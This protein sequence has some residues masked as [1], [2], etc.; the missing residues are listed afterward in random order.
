MA[1]LYLGETEF[2]GPEILAALREAGHEVEV[3][4]HLGRLPHADDLARRYDLIVDNAAR[5]PDD[6]RAVARA[7]GHG[8]GHYVLLSSYLVYPATLRLRP[9]R[10]SDVDVRVD[11]SVR[12][13][14]EEIA[15]VRAVERE[16]HLLCRGQF[17]FTIL[18]PALIDGPGEPSGR[19][20]WFT[21]RILDGG[22]LILPDGK[23]P[24]FRHVSARDLGRAVRTVA[25]A[26]RAFGQTINV[27]SQG[28]F[29]YWGYAAMLRDGLGVELTFRQVPAARWRAAGLSL[30]LG[31][32]AAAAFIE[33][34][35]LLTELGWTPAEEWDVMV[36]L[37]QHLRTH[38][39]VYD[40]AARHR[41]CQVLAESEAAEGRLVPG[42]LP[43]PMAPPRFWRLMAHAGQPASLSF[44]PLPDSDHEHVPLLK[45]R[46]LVLGPAEAMLLRGDLITEPGP[47]AIGHNALLEVLRAGPGDPSPGATC[48]PWAR[49]P[50]GDPRCGFCQ[51]GHAR[52]LG[53]D[54]D[55][56]GYG[57][58]HTPAPH[59][60]EVPPPLREVALLADPLAC[61]LHGLQRLLTE[62]AGPVWICGRG[63]D[64]ALASWLAQ[65]AGRPVVHVD[66]QPL[67]HPEFP[68]TTLHDEIL[69]V[70]RGEKPA[71]TLTIE[72]SGRMVAWAP[73]AEALAPGGVR[74]A[75]L[76]PAAAPGAQ[77]FHP[78]PLCAPDR[79]SVVEAIAL[80]RR[81][82]SYRDLLLRIGPAVPLWTPGDVFLAPPFTQPYLTAE[83]DAQV[84][85]RGARP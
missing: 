78:L 35:P 84:V 54:C 38:G 10:E 25:G 76:R 6:I 43:A 85:P 48:V 4:P 13:L 37:A 59:L 57:V 61:L 12:G 34:S 45:T 3:A 58:C 77:G 83:E 60:I 72:L 51:G 29:N 50:C 16:L 53:L 67:A 74:C 36:P 26:A 2:V 8:P 49:L 63:V 21:N 1:A 27:A 71:P 19:A 5:S 9:Y 24:I 15:L 33:Q 82:A 73:M 65:D 20:S 80:L 70:R 55:G 31:E 42:Q 44:Q 32:R 46:R 23:L 11:L 75:Y 39:R 68:I 47:R 81:W 56:Y 66:L 64:A 40:R 79:Q 18:R 30:P 14:P 28:T 69:A 52:V 41:E 7:L 22:L 17:P 62:H